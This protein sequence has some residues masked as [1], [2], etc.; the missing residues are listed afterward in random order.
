MKRS[1]LAAAALG[2]AATLL[3]GCG[4]GGGSGGSGSGSSDPIVVGSINALSG[5]ATFPEASE[6]AKAVFDQ[7]NASGG[8]NGRQIKY[9]ITDDKADPATASANARQIVGSDGAVAM[10]GSASLIDCQT[11]AAYYERNK[12]LS[13]QG[14][15]IDPQCFNTPNIAP[16]NVGPYTDTQMSLTYGSEVLGLKKICALLEINGASGPPY[17][18]AIDAWSKATGK[19][20]FKLD[21]SVP[22]G[23]SDFTPYIVAAKQAGCD[24]VWSNA[25]EPDGVGQLKAAAAQGWNDVTFLYLT[26]VYTNQFAQAA[27]FVGKGVYVPAEFAPYTE[28]DDPANKDW[29]A[30]MEKNNI[31]LTSFGQGGYLAATHFVDV[32]KAIQGD[33]TRESVT[34]ALQGMKEI[35]NPMSGTPWVFGPGDSH[36]PNRAGFPIKLLPGTKQWQ[37]TGDDPIVVAKQ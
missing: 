25:P 16:V 13:I 33:I 15:G 9:E 3:A 18:A 31:A 24:A 4:S 23:G 20:L 8:I 36:S 5:P 21:D 32:V 17:R 34:K 10:V 2:A 27:T 19:K 1:L 37:D 12:V 26:S 11:N 6:A 30:L 29:R 7:V 22:F 35:D 14:T 28:A